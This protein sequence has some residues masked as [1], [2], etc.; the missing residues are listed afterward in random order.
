MAACHPGL[1]SWCG[2]ADSRGSRP[3]PY[4][5]G[6]ARWCRRKRSRGSR[7]ELCGH[8]SWRARSPRIGGRAHARGW[9]TFVPSE[10]R[11]HVPWS[12]ACGGLGRQQV[13][14]QSRRRAF[15]RCAA[16]C[17]RGGEAGMAGAAC[18]EQRG[19]KPFHAKTKPI[20]H[21]ARCER[22]ALAGMGPRRISKTNWRLTTW[23]G[24]RNEPICV[25]RKTEDGR[26]A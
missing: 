6:R 11:T 13:S 21:V 18:G 2:A 14:G 1:G 20:R 10:P 12:S 8:V 22:K 3:E 16:P 19:T 24:F 5:V 25:R 4:D 23:Q 15:A 7:P 26:W 17:G 9:M